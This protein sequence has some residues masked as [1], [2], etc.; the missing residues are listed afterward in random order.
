MFLQHPLQLFR[1]LANH[2]L[3]RKLCVISRVRVAVLSK[4]C[5]GRN[6]LLGDV[7]RSAQSF[8][9]SHSIDN[10]GQQTGD[11]GANDGVLVADDLRLR[12]DRDALDERDVFDDVVERDVAVF[13]EEL[14]GVAGLVEEDEDDFVQVGF[15]V[16][17]Q[18]DEQL[19]DDHHGCTTNLKR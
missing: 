6:Y 5:D 15:H 18:V 9:N 8:R 17:F 1:L 13:A 3:K 2:P 14:V 12:D 10:V 4:F 19:A 7:F 11:G 16:P